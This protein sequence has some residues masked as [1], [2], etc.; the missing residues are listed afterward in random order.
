MSATSWIVAGVFVAVM[1]AWAF[2]RPPT[3]QII[4]GT[5][6]GAVS[7]VVDRDTFYLRGQGERF[8]VWG[9]DAP[10]IDAQGGN[11]AAGYLHR[12]ISKKQLTCE[13]R[14][15]DRYGRYVA[16]CILPDGTDIAAELI[17]AGHA[18]ELT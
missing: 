8:R 15:K 9:I 17:R 18:V 4:S 7:R 2:Q 5:V 6:T 13:I 1:L 3:E 16:R 12:L 11:A 14:S 10:E